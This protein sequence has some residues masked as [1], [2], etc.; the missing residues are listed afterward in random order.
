M[1]WERSGGDGSNERGLGAPQGKGEPHDALPDLCS[2]S[3]RGQMQRQPPQ[4]SDCASDVA[5]GLVEVYWQ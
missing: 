1:E 5:G 3:L 4:R 2:A